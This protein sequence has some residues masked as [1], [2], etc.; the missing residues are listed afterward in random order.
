MI[1]LSCASR[2]RKKSALMI[3]TESA[4]N[5]LNASVPRSFIVLY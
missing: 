4:N 1:A 2:V 3:A 5:R